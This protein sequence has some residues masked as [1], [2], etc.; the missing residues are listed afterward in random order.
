MEARRKEFKSKEEEQRLDTLVTETSIHLH[1]HIKR[2][3][4]AEQKWNKWEPKYTGHL[5]VEAPFISIF[6]SMWCFLWVLLSINLNLN[7]FEID[8][9]AIQRKINVVKQEKLLDQFRE[10]AAIEWSAN[11]KINSKNPHPGSRLLL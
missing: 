5:L 3:A 2:W 6:E 4:V 7:Y 1:Q 8:P 10:Y 9:D 11:Y